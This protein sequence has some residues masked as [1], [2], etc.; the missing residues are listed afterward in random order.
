MSPRAK[1]WNWLQNK[2]STNLA[3]GIGGSTKKLDFLCATGEEPPAVGVQ[4][5]CDILDIRCR[6]EVDTFHG[7]LSPSIS[8]FSTSAG[9]THAETNIVKRTLYLASF[10]GRL[11]LCF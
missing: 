5:F 3:S 11:P 4:N 6:M 1:E 2:S 10:P 8:R 7:L 9:T